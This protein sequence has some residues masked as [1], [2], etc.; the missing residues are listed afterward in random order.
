LH[1]GVTGL[2]NA[3]Q[4]FWRL[5]GSLTRS[6]IDRAFLT[7]YDCNPSANLNTNSEK[8]NDIFVFQGFKYE[9]K[10]VLNWMHNGG[11]QNDYFSIEKLNTA[12]VFKPLDVV[13]AEAKQG[14][15]RRFEYVDGNPDKG[16]NYYRVRLV[17]QNGIE[18]YSE[19]A[20]LNF[21]DPKELY[22]YPNPARHEVSLN[23]RGWEHESATIYVYNSFGMVLKQVDLQD[24]SDKPYLLQLE[25][26][27]GS[28]QYFVRVVTPGKKNV[29]KPLI[30]LAE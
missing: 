19:I 25:S 20:K 11:D 18:K 29:V 30:I 28:G 9:G 17:Q 1:V 22:L 16:D 4:V 12:G 13:S 3:F 24:I 23:L 15:T 7:S 8:Y 27:W 6:P 5:P 14:E 10:S 2:T 26:N 21:D